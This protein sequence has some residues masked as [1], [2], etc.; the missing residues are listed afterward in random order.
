MNFDKHARPASSRLFAVRHRL[1]PNARLGIL[2]TPAAL[3][4]GIKIAQIFSPIAPA[5][6]GHIP[7]PDAFRMIEEISQAGRDRKQHAS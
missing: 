7:S 4:T 2:V 6:R 1:C 5:T 3:P